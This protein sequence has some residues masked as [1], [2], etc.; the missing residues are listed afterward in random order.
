MKAHEYMS[1]SAQNFSLLLASV[2]QFQS[3]HINIILKL[4]WYKSFY[5]ISQYKR[6]N[7]IENTFLLLQEESRISPQQKPLKC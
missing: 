4:K 1:G 2:I 5:F 7:V 3:Y 6:S